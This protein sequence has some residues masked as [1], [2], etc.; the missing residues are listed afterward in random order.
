M[1][2]SSKRCCYFTLQNEKVANTPQPNIDKDRVQEITYISPLLQNCSSCQHL[3]LD[4]P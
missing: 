2:S 1:P 4:Y 3:L